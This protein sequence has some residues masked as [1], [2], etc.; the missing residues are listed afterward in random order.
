MLW[1]KCCKGF[2]QM[3]W[4]QCCKGVGG[5]CVGG[6]W[7]CVVVVVDDFLPLMLIHVSC[8]LNLRNQR[9]HAKHVTFTNSHTPLREPRP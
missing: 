8:T 5:L 4:L 6:W 7:L 2:R 1:L 3:L 9:A